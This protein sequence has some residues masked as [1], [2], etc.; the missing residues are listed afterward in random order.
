[1][2]GESAQG[3]AH[4]P[5]GRVN[6]RLVVTLGAFLAGTAAA[7]FG[8][9]EPFVD[10]LSKESE[11]MNK[12][13]EKLDQAERLLA[14]EPELKEEL[15]HLRRRASIRPAQELVGDLVKFLESAR[16]LHGTNS[17]YRAVSETDAAGLFRRT[18]LEIEGDATPRGMVHLLNHLTHWDEFFDI[19]RLVVKT[20]ERDRIRITL[21][22]SILSAKEPVRVGD[23]AKAKGDP[24]VRSAPESASTFPKLTLG[25]VFGISPVASNPPTPQGDPKALPA[26]SPTRDRGVLY[27][28]GIY[29][30]SGGRLKGVLEDRDTKE[31]HT[32]GAG[33]SVAGFLVDSVADDQLVLSRGP[34]TVKLQMGDHLVVDR[35]GR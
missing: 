8:L 9:L 10:K 25:R 31:V 30:G 35:K 16:T 22:C 28:R 29:L 7:W 34:E 5:A 17:S 15:T 4:T 11:K 18:E 20:G 32:V 24:L 21:G 26:P 23:P 14:R 3:T 27:L 1:M 19:E 12:A 2:T 33:D 6:L 13:S